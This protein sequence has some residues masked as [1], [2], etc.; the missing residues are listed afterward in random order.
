[1]ED[2]DTPDQDNFIADE[3]SIKRYL[4]LRRIAYKNK[5]AK[6]ELFVILEPNQPPK[7]TRGRLK[8][9]IA[10]CFQQNTERVSLSAM[11]PKYNFWIYF[12]GRDDREAVGVED[13]SGGRTTPDSSQLNELGSKLFN[14]LRSAYEEF[15]HEITGTVIISMQTCEENTLGRTECGISKSVWKDIQ[16]FVRY[17]PVCFRD[18]ESALSEI[19]QKIN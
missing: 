13:P 12:I 5:I 7:L 9:W 1:M 8:K 11:H 6:E 19:S 17:R 3:K 2:V 15:N 10:N 18:K 14:K 16:K 4:D